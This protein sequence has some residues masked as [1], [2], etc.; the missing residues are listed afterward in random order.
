VEQSVTACKWMSIW[1]ITKFNVAH[2]LRNRLT[3]YI[4]TN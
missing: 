3:T 1:N 2:V 4:Y